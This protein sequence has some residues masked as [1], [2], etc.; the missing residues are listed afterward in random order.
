[1]FLSLSE[2]QA[3][4]VDV[5]GRPL[6]DQLG[7]IEY[8]Q[9]GETWVAIH[10]DGIREF[11]P[12]GGVPA[13]AISDSASPGPSGFY[14]GEPLKL[15][16]GSYPKAVAIGDVTGDGRP[17][18]VMT[19]GFYF[20]PDNDYKLFLFR[21]M[22]DGT[23]AAPVRYSFGFHVA[24]G[25][26]T[27]VTVVDL[28]E[29]GVG[30]VVVG[31]PTGITVLLAD[32]Q[33]G[34]RDGVVISDADAMD[35]AAT[36]VDLDGHKDIVSLGNTRGATIFYGDG[37][38]GF[39]QTQHLTT[40]ARGS[41]DLEAGDLT[42]DGVDDLAVMSGNYGAYVAIHRHNGVS[43]YFG[44]DVY[45]RPDTLFGG[46]GLGDVSGDGLNDVVLSRPFNRP[47]WLTVMTQN[48]ST[49]RLNDPTTI[50]T[51]DIPEAVQVIDVNRDGRDDVVVLHATWV[52]LGLYLQT[53]SGGLSPEIFY[54]IPYGF[55]SGRSLAIG[56]LSSDGCVDV[57][58][59]NPSAKLVVLYG[60]GCV[61]QPTLCD[62][63]NP[64]TDD[65]CDSMTGCVHVNN[66]A[67]CDDGDA[68]TVGDT[69]GGSACQPG[70]P[71]VL[72]TECNDRN[73]C[74]KESCDPELG[75]VHAP[76]ICND[77]DPN[78]VDSCDR[79]R[80]CVFKPRSGHAFNNSGAPSAQGGLN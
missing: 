6:A 5:Y 74:T 80:G 51:I 14:F 39:R 62:D 13:S 78:T 31:H 21:Q 25:N 42:G 32:G 72:K 4:P 15:F 30:D 28:D 47:T 57:A 61:C 36:D 77:H 60:G 43:G 35:L 50:T 58:M 56:D 68:C 1:M 45:G 7:P 53:P 11:A 20:E 66:S 73:A 24:Y 23:L 19:T 59:A 79:N 75:C 46:V 70:R 67:P 37:H 18:V 26:T 12:L 54:P 33:G 17:D 71:L 9:Q 38:G 27:S 65:S 2:A 41:N 48:P 10:A 69:C 34:L 8:R 22:A 44:Y 16:T 64:C 63:H 49:H 40:N 3:V 55:N 29:D 76:I 52:N